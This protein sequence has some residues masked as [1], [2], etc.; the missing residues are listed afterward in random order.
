MGRQDGEDEVGALDGVGEVGEEE[1]ASGL[2]RW[3]PQMGTPEVL[4]LKRENMRNRLPLVLFVSGR[5]DHKMP[6]DNC[7]QQIRPYHSFAKPMPRL[8]QIEKSWRT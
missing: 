7:S 4:R 6:V 8:P 3:I 1:K 2:I 5:N